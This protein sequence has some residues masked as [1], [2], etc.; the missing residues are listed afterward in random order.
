MNPLDRL[1]Q[2]LRKLEGLCSGTWQR[3]VIPRLKLAAKFLGLIV[4]PSLLCVLAINFTISA[5]PEKQSIEVLEKAIDARDYEKVKS[6]LL[7]EV[8]QNPTDVAKHFLYLS[9]HFDQ[10]LKDPYRASQ[11]QKRVHSYYEEIA[12]SS[13]TQIADIGNWGLGFLAYRERQYEGAL[14]Y[15]EAV[16]NR[17]LDFLHYL[18]GEVYAEQGNAQKAE[19]H[20]VREI[21]FGGACSFAFDSL[22]KLLLEQRRYDAITRFY[23]DPAW[24]EELPSQFLPAIQLLNLDLLDYSKSLYRRFTAGLSI[25]SLSIVISG[26]FAWSLLILLIGR[27]R[28]KRAVWLALA[29]LLGIFAEVFQRFS[30]DIAALL[31]GYAFT[32]FWQPQLF[33]TLLISAT[34][35]EIAKILPFLILLK[36]SRQIVQ[37]IDYILYAS[38]IALGYAS[39]ENLGYFV[40]DG[41]SG[42]INRE[43]SG[44]AIHCFFTATFAYVLLAGR[45]KSMSRKVLYLISGLLL[46][47]SL[48]GMNNFC[49]TAT[50]S[51]LLMR[52]LGGLAILYYVRCYNKMINKT[53]SQSG[54]SSQEILGRANR[55]REYFAYGMT[56]TFLLGYF[57]SVWK[58]GPGVFRFQGTE[59]LMV[60]WVW[61]Y[62]FS[63]LIGNHSVYRTVWI[64]FYGRIRHPKALH[65]VLTLPT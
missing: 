9:A 1:D 44:T 46:A 30:S 64:P 57:L 55:A 14:E 31:T 23:E 6:T 27:L 35:E 42:N 20:F 34:T 4:L 10:W 3:V 40:Y 50:Y 51:F 37:P 39:V 7:E 65:E 58:F 2:L 54:E 21:K 60:L 49:A 13:D 59:K 19:E 43:M 56:M 17:E 15:F 62:A 29:V 36:W 33:P 5:P 63:Y 24:K 25:A 61:L 26:L 47:S 12:N 8:E 52:V 41:L 18:M 38:A 45:G 28:G 48:H 11:D 22:V 32:G 53:L 16:T